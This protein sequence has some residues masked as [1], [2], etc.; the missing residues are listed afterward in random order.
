MRDVLQS[1]RAAEV[2][3]RMVSALGGP[4]DFVEGFERYLARAP[5]VHEVTAGVEGFVATIDTR[6]LG[7]AV[8]ELGG[9]RRRASDAVDPSVGLDHLAGLG[10]SVE[11]DTPIAIVHAGSREAALAAEARIRAAYGFGERP[12]AEFPLVIERIG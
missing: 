11:G 7:Y 8:V 2:F 4:A 6:A 12:G 9:G 10:T 3:G 5:V 1:G